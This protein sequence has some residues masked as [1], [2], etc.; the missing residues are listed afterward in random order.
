MR[1]RDTFGFN[2]FKNA[3]GGAANQG[4]TLEAST[5]RSVG[6]VG[7]LIGTGG[8]MR[9]GRERSG[10]VALVDTHE[11]RLDPHGSRS[12]DPCI[13]SSPSSP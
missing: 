9:E 5:S 8:G 11:P 7:R 2:G 13:Y 3:Q 10:L 6:C 12:A 4:G 1:M